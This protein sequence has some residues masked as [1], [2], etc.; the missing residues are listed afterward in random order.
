MEKRVD[1]LIIGGGLAGLMATLAAREKGVD[2]ALVIKGK[3]CETG[4]SVIAG[5][6]LAA[7]LGKEDDSAK[8]H[9]EDTVKAGFY[10]N[11]QEVAFSMAEAAK[12]AIELIN[13]LGVDFA[14]DKDGTFL[15]YP[16][17]GHSE[18]RSIRTGKGGF[19][20]IDSLS[21]A[22]QKS[23]A[24]VIS[25]VIVTSILKTKGGRA[26]GAE[27]TNL[28]TGEKIRIYAKTTIMATGGLGGLFPL[29]SNSP[30]LSGDGYA[31]ALRAGAELADMEFIQFTPTAL[32][33]P[34]EMRG[35]STGGGILG[36]KGVIML[37][38][39]G[40][41]F[42]SKYAPDTMEN[43]TRDVLARAIQRE[44]VE[45][46]GTANKGIYLD[47]TAVKP[48]DIYNITGHFIRRMQKLG[49]DPVK[50]PI[51]IAPA[52]HFFMGG[53][54]I[55]AKGETTI[56]GLYAVGE[57]ATGVHGA[58]RLSSNGLTEAAAFG[59][60][61]GKLAGEEV[62]QIK[63]WDEIEESSDFFFVKQEKQI[64]EDNQSKFKEILVLNERFK[65]IMFASGGI[66][67]VE[68][69]IKNGL[70]EISIIE[71]KV[72]NMKSDNHQNSIKLFELLN[73]VIVGKAILKSALYR[74]ES[75]GA[76]YRSDYPQ[77][78]N[79]NWIKNIIVKL[80]GEELT[81]ES[82]PVEL[83][84]VKYEK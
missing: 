80:S 59:R 49:I 54:R 37:N 44:I 27:G 42:M 26:S 43:S 48:E 1:I 52:M 20:I 50:E 32:A 84:Y 21:K 31:L 14:K 79:D 28:I 61:T 65:E 2:T 40:E 19:P 11:N 51:E 67:R 64:E 23:G 56:P 70:Q 17:P 6:G 8:Q 33:Y 66:E 25:D 75:R 69:G 12:E 73:K 72:K 63:D 71:E 24:Q 68:T 3:L 29:T 62:K 82:K 4:N 16:I 5:G 35:V 36:Q 10:I 13:K 81:I 76:H 57:V 46:R 45:G 9:L 15:Q 60:L 58:N 22:V 34:E 77:L 39:K 83:T 18:D 41:R 38:S 7:F 55:N 78:D 47:M 30:E 74:T 53:I